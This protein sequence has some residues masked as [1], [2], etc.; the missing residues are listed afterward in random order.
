MYNLSLI[1]NIRKHIDRETCLVMSHLDYCNSALLGINDKCL[2]FLQ[3]VQ[4]MSA[5]I[6]LRR[7]KFS[8]NWEAF[9]ELYWQ[10]IKSRIE[11]KC[12][13]LV[14]ASTTEHRIIYLNFYN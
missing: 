10:P 8:S 13:C 14:C 7:K 5:K 9:K 2:K 3:R 12:M 11:F 4:N 1:R 6:I